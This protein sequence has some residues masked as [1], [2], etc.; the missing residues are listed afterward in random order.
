MGGM[1]LHAHKPNYPPPPDQLAF[2]LQAMTMYVSAGQ[3]VV[4]FLICWVAMVLSVVR[5]RRRVSAC[6]TVTCLYLDNDVAASSPCSVFSMPS[7]TEGARPVAI[8][9]HKPS[10]RAWPDQ[11]GNQPDNGSG[12]DVATP[13]EFAI[14]LEAVCQAELLL[15]CCLSRFVINRQDYLHPLLFACVGLLF[16]SVRQQA[17][18]RRR[19]AHR[20]SVE[21]LVV[22]PLWLCQGV[23]AVVLGFLTLAGAV[24]HIGNEPPTERVRDTITNG[25]AAVCYVLVYTAVFAAQAQCDRLASRNRTAAAAAERAAKI[26]AAVHPAKLRGKRERGGPRGRT[27]RDESLP[28]WGSLA[29]P[30][31]RAMSDDGSSRGSGCLSPVFRMDSVHVRNSGGE[32]YR[33]LTL[34]VDGQSEPEAGPMQQLYTPSGREVASQRFTPVNR[35]MWKQGSLIGQGGFG[36]VYIGFNTATGELMAVKNIP[37][38]HA[39]QLAKEK[40]QK[41]QME[42]QTMKNLDHPNIV[43][44]FFTERSG[45][46]VNIF[47]EYVPGGSIAD[48]LKQFGALCTGTVCYYTRQIL[49]GLRYLHMKG[50][51][52]RDIK[53]G[54]I[55]ITVSGE[56]K[57]GDFGAAALIG[58]L[59]AKRKSVAGTPMWM[60]PEIICQKEYNQSVDVWSLGCTVI[61]MMTGNPPFAHMCENQMDYL[62]LI[63]GDNPRLIF[64]P[65]CKEDKDL[66]DMLQRCL[67]QN[68]ASRPSAMQLLLHDFILKAACNEDTLQGRPGVVDALS[69]LSGGRLSMMRIYYNVWVRFLLLRRMV[70]QR[71]QRHRTMLFKLL[72]ESMSKNHWLMA[73]CYDKLR[74]FV[75]QRRRSKLETR[76]QFEIQREE[77]SPSRKTGGVT[78]LRRGEEDQAS[79]PSH[80]VD[81]SQH[82]LASTPCDSQLSMAPT[83]DRL[84]SFKSFNKTAKDR[85]FV[86][87]AHARHRERTVHTHTHTATPVSS[88]CSL[89]SSPRQSQLSEASPPTPWHSRRFPSPETVPVPSPLSSPDRLWRHMS[90]ICRAAGLRQVWFPTVPAPSLPAS[91]RGLTTQT[92]ST[93]NLAEPHRFHGAGFLRVP[94]RS[95]GLSVLTY[96]AV[97]ILRDINQP[98]LPSTP[99]AF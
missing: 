72:Q 42:I 90:P 81:S 54:N 39:D 77:L 93:F 4:V 83:W 50:V 67:T 24:M 85:Y 31:R 88:R 36:K 94:L 28:G 89:S 78:A 73:A 76:Y 98:Q 44:Y 80:S 55:L 46:S 95:C 35:H 38:N 71:F 14:L 19:T 79:S 70:P 13:F 58:G 1:F 11:P 29:A 64:P 92:T 37:F 22:Q 53:G 45:D 41:L 96:I 26:A 8:G 30:K 91:P 61:E 84:K 20:P 2:W 23:W 33:S 97:S 65:E 62:R 51:I 6:D 86:R 7:H 3:A 57:L 59:Q 69:L 9:S 5:E 75:E 12:E 87:W 17:S 60:A 40:L 25:V 34:N 47:M 68:P 27:T 18:V 56:C 15:L 16:T 49:L 66:H 52:H 10:H 99:S 48:L 32:Q 74:L 43:K 63:T 82:P 21:V